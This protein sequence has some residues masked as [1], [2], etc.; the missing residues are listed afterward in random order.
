MVASSTID[1]KTSFV[2]RPDNLNKQR[3]YNVFVVS[4]RLHRAGG[5]PKIYF[6]NDPA[7][8]GVT[9]TGLKSLDSNGSLIFGTGMVMAV[10]HRLG[11]VLC[12]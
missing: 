10:F 9:E 7:S 6:S 5:N 2:E 11:L 12:K 1:L 8:T 3:L 4:V